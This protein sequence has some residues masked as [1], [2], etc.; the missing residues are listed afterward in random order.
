M[1]VE[2]I[3]CVKDK[4]V[5]DMEISMYE[6]RLFTTWCENMRVSSPGSQD[7]LLR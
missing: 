2:L 6:T 7:L 4:L 5:W 3:I 1:C